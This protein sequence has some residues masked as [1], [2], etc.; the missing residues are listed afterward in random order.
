MRQH[1]L[2]GGKIG[3]QPGDVEFRQGA[4]GALGRDREGRSVVGRAHH[5]GQQWV[6]LRR[7]RIAQVAGRIDP[8]P[9]PGGFLVGA[10]GARALDVHPGLHRE[11]PWPSDRG[12]ICQP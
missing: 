6:E 3:W 1:G 2:Q 9:R 5:L 11:S 12:L 10:E 8:H 4:A 7:W